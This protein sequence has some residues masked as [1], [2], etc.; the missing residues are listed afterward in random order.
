[1]ADRRQQALGDVREQLREARHAPN[2]RAAYQKAWTAWERHCERAGIADPLAPAAAEVV[3][4]F[5]RL[6]TEPSPAA[7]RLL[8]LSTVAQYRAALASRFARAGRA[9]PGAAEV[10]DTLA[11]LARIRGAEPRQVRALAPPEVAAMIAACPES[12]R[13]V[14]D[15]ALLAVGFAGALRRDE[16]IRITVRDMQVDRDTP[17]APDAPD[18]AGLRMTIRIP[19]SKTDQ[20][21][22]GCRVPVPDGSVIRPVT[23]ALAW[24]A[25]GGHGET[26]GAPLF[27]SVYR[28]GRLTGRPLLGDDVARAV[29]HYAGAIGLDPAHYAGHS[30][31]AG[32][33]TSAAIS[34]ARL[35]KIMEV[36]RHK[37]TDMVLR[38]IRDADSFAD[39]A[40]AGFL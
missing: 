31:R 23:R 7:G 30:L 32:F 12:T 28:G 37:S 27:Q 18:A 13:G 40:G 35:D 29:K 8:A 39:H 36:S 1:M 11:A 16:L 25:V 20:A 5:V 3:D 6:G 15:A 2:T 34:G 19:R 17:D 9:L 24:L 4:W 26:P 21:G 33:I 22:R 10:G 14:R 38:Y